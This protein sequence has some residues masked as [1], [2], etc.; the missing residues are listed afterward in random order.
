MATMAKAALKYKEIISK[1]YEIHKGSPKL[2]QLNPKKENIGTLKRIS[3]GV[4]N[5]K[6]ANKT[7]LLVGETGT[8]KST[9]INALVNFAIG[10][11]WEDDVWFQI[12]EDEKKDQSQSQTS[13]VIVYNICGLEDKTLPYSLTIID[14][15]GYGDTGGIE[16]DE[17]VR[18][19]L[20]DLFRSE[21]GIH[22][23]NA[24]G[25]VLKA[26]ENR[27]SDRLSYIFNSV[28]SLFGKDL[29]HNMVALITHSPGGTPKN[30]LEALN[31]ANIKCA[32]NDKK[33]PVHFLFNNCQNEPRKE[34]ID[35]LRHAYNKA[36]KGM[37]QFTDF[38]KKT[39]PQRLETT[40]HV[41]N[42][43]I[44]LTACVQNL[45]ERVQSVKSKLNEIHQTRMGLKKYQEAMKSFEGFTMEVDQPYKAKESIKGGKWGGIFF[46]G[47]VTC[48]VCEE[49]CHFPGC[50][51]AR[52]PSGCEVMKNG[53]CTSCTNRCPVEDHVKED[54]R[55][56]TKTKKVRITMQDVKYN[57][58]KTRA[59]TKMK[60]N[61]LENL[62][63]EMENLEQ[64][65]TQYLY[66]SYDHVVKL[67]KIALNVD[68]V[69]TYVHLDFLIE[70]ME[71]KRDTG[72]I[73]KLKEM[74]SRKDKGVLAGVQY[75]YRKFLGN[76]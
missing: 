13:D 70:E 12:V 73:Q 47:A 71:K 37:E 41:L 67:E 40:V 61:I 59:Q 39:A 57:Y 46:K 62:E 19:R 2:Y 29:E 42:E 43:R 7:I 51:V 10:V 27:L 35:D 63:K 25:L 75:L 34:D 36:M 48:K 22:E 33:Q 45:Q 66:E 64:R 4:K 49:N 53:R 65:K 11:K 54:W 58:E 50:T 56:V 55:Y 52:S 24:V 72:K 14:T 5:P 8:G 74:S 16:H 28:V 15:P 76:K 18:Q 1:S 38:L 31:A 68:S 32:R 3:F 9:M 17:I 30:A 26:G 20:F 21:D 69:S 23:I 60:M 44:G 6:R